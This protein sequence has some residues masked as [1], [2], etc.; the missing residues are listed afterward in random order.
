MEAIRIAASFLNRLKRF[1]DWWHAL[2][3][4]MYAEICS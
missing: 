1:R 4:R 2:M 3:I